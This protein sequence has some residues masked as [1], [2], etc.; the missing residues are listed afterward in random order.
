MRGSGPL[1]NGSGPGTL[2]MIFFLLRRL[3]YAT[4]LLFFV[5]LVSFFIIELPPGDYLTRRMAELEA[6]GDHSAR[7]QLEAYRSRY[8]LDRSILE[9]Y[10]IWISNFVRGD[11]GE[12]FEFQR[13]VREIIGQ[14]LNNTLIL[15]GSV[16]LVTWLVA[17]PLGVFSAVKQYS[18]GD[19]II[20]TISFIGLGIP[21]F[22]LALIVLYI[23]VMYFNLEI[24]GLFSPAF[25]DAPWS[26]A[27]FLDLLKHL[28]IPVVVAS[29]TS[30]AGLLRI[31]RSNLLDNLNQPFTESARARGLR[32]T[33]VVWKHA[34]RMAINPL[35]VILGSEALP[36]I[37]VGNALIAIVLNLPTIGP[38]FVAALQKQDMYLAGT[39]L[40]F[41]TL[42]MVIGNLLA[43]ILLAWLD[44]RI[45][46]G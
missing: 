7:F 33:T 22:L 19:Q 10:V 15:A 8:G 3:G 18:I 26:V 2:P 37:I 16:L 23:S 27:R 14:R 13:P 21:G 34:V 38:L 17:I 1:P 9:R 11:F 42:L 36:S 25:R 39:I 12:S 44:P 45:R 30:S 29:V 31:M 6:R 5:S 28:W 24:G 32:E 43:D 20:T 41:Y 46:I 40:M 4:V 35:V